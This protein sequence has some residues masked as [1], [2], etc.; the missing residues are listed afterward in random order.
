MTSAIEHI[1]T[2]MTVT[3]DA[4]LTLNALQAELAK[5]GQWL[6]IDPPSPESLSIASLLAHNLSGPRRFG[7]GTIRDYVIGMKVHLAD[8]RTI[9]CGGKVVKNVA[10]YDL[11]KLFI[12]AGN[13]LGMIVEA[14]FKL[15]PRPE[16]EQFMQKPCATLADAG[17]AINAVL[18]S[19]L[20]PTVLDLHCVNT[21]PL[22]LVLGF[23][24]SR[25]EVDWQLTKAR[26]LG[27]VEPGNLEYEKKFWATQPDSIRKLSVLPSKLIETIEQ[28]GG[29]RFVARAGNGIL[30]HDGQ[31]QRRDN[32]LPVHLWQRAKAAFDPKNILAALPS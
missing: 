27:F 4:S 28:S 8:G 15:R 25:E 16:A 17:A 5:G 13:T 14:T 10:G 2:D 26:E 32:N 1:P 12:G 21:N 3:A 11:Q 19:P 24:G 7:Y 6:P 29:G 23:D 18:D 31:P 30:Y 9:K 22:F 20:T